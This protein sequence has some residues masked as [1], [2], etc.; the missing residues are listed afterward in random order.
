MQVIGKKAKMKLKL[1]PLLLTIFLSINGISQIKYG[2]NNGKY[3]TI[4]GT[5]LY[6]EEYGKGIPLLLL[7]GGLGSI[8]DFKKCIPNLSKKYKVIAFDAPGLGRSEFADSTMTYKLMAHYYSEAIDLLKLDSTY[9]VGWSDGGNVALLLAKIRPDK[10]KKIAVSGATY[11]LE[12]TTKESLEDINKFSD[13]TWVIKEL[14]P[15][16]KQYK[17]KSPTG[18]WKKYITE[19]KRM[20]FEEIYFQK[21][22][23]IEINTPTLLVYG[24]RDMYTTELGLELHRAIKKSQFCI[25]PNTSHDVFWEKPDLINKILID[26][27]NKR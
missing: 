20:W 7:H 10:I 14:K 2:S 19:A 6:Y 13:T 4:R 5:K 17:E 3:L 8:T 1:L 21:S 24:D 22:V 25:L 9:V 18:N 23:L 27:F 15:W 16:I 11:K 12:G 26:F